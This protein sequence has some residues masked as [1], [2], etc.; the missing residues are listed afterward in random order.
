VAELCDRYLDDAKS[1]RLLTRRKLAKK[2]ST[3]A[4]DANRIECHV[5]PLLGSLKVAAVTFEDVDQFM[6]DVANGKSAPG[7]GGKGTAR[8]TVGLLG[9]IF[10]YAVRHRMRLDN[11]CRGIERFAENRRERRLSEAEYAQL[12]AALRAVTGVWPHAVAAMRFIA[13]TGWRRGEVLGLR[14]DE[15]DPARRTAI[16][17]D[18]KTGR[19]VRPLPPTSRAIAPDRTCGTSST[20]RCRRRTPTGS[21]PTRRSATVR[22][23]Q[24][25]HPRCPRYLQYPAAVD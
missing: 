6:H 16:L 22:V 24:A 20:P 11:P 10:G 5:K 14:W 8:R 12:G 3:L 19:S 9:A 4:T 13:L 1:G 25:G 15:I 23:L 21:S 18:T 17:G 2:P 7:R